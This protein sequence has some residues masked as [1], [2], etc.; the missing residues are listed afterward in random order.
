MLKKIIS[1]RCFSI[2]VSAIPGATSNKVRRFYDEVTVVPHPMQDK[3]GEVHF[4]GQNEQ[5][6]FKN[7]SRVSKDTQYWAIK[8]DKRV[9]KTMYKEELYIPSR[10]LAVALAQ[11]WDSQNEVID[12]RQFHLNYVVAKAVHLTQDDTL[13]GNLQAELQRILEND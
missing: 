2:G 4:L 9:I 3:L 11:E 8:L 1:K 5:A 13:V 12:L 7:M 10:A 6:S